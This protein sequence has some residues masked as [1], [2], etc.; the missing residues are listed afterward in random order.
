MTSEVNPK[1]QGSSNPG[2]Q[3]DFT[4]GN[5]LKGDSLVGDST[6]AARIRDC[7][8]QLTRTSGSSSAGTTT[9]R[10]LL[11]DEQEPLQKCDEV[12]DR[13]VGLEH[14]LAPVLDILSLLKLLLEQ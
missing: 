8:V 7:C 10:A 12:D 1:A 9:L 6:P 11:L 14:Q 3:A 5:C 2:P 4:D 13:E